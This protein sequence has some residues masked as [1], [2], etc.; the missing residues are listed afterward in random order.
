MKRN[1]AVDYSDVSIDF[2]IVRGGE[3]TRFV[4]VADVSGSM[5]EFASP[6]PSSNM[7]ISQDFNLNFD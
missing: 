3:P 4:V 1:V 7:D 2:H 6:I 5:K